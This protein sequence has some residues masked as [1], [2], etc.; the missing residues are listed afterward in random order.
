MLIKQWIFCLNAFF[1]AKTLGSENDKV[2]NISN[3][4]RMSP[5]PHRL[6]SGTHTARNVPNGN[7]SSP[8]PMLSWRH[9]LTSWRAHFEKSCGKC[10]ECQSLCFSTHLLNKYL[11]LSS[12]S[13]RNKDWAVM[14]GSKTDPRKL[15]SLPIDNRE[16][17]GRGPYCLG[18]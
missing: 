9:V 8:R 3:V 4:L 13:S 1:D 10:K 2:T 11:K 5:M 12:K 18:S 6:N 17:A 15:T 16:N 7:K 14:M